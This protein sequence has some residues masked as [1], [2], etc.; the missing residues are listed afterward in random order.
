MAL[1]IARVSQNAQSTPK[2]TFT[3][4]D[5]YMDLR[6]LT[7][8]TRGAPVNLMCDNYFDYKWAL[9]YLRDMPQEEKVERIGLFFP[10]LRSLMEGAKQSPPSKYVLISRNL[11]EAVWKNEKFSLVPVSD[12]FAPIVAVSPANGAETVDGASFVWLSNMPSSFAVDSPREGQAILWA[13]KTLVRPSRPKDIN[14][15]VVVQTDLGTYDQRVQDALS[16]PLKLKR[17]MNSIQLWCRELPTLKVLPNGDGRV[18]LLG[19]ED[20][21]IKLVPGS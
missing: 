17:G 12:E 20:Y 14:R 18:L 10:E 16:I 1:T 5:P 8:V 19:L 9:I 4:L 6:R 11:P 2:K 7:N 15:T 3:K 13:R 21:Q